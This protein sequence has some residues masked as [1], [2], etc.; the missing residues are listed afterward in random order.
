MPCALKET[1]S[2]LFAYV[3]IIVITVIIWWLYEDGAKATDTALPRRS[4]A[5]PGVR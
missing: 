2:G 1:A 4:A 3:F 5:A